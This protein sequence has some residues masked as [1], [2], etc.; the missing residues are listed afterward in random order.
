MEPFT[1]R[2]SEIVHAAIRIIAEK[3]IQELTT[4]NLAE[5]VGISEPALYRHFRNKTAILKGILDFFRERSVGIFERIILREPE[6][7]ARLA[8]VVRELCRHLADN[9]AF[10][11]VVFSEVIFRSESELA[12]GVEGL[13]SAARK[14]LS[15]IL[16]GGAE[17][18]EFRR[19]IPVEHMVLVVM[20]A[21]RLLATRWHLTGYGFD[22][23]AEGDAL[24]GSLVRLLGSPKGERT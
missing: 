19:D 22:L 13:M 18:G 12:P 14:N 20:G 4:K 2:Q 15:D 9:P 16:A 8:A 6:G 10:S 21:L 23:A 24:A 7:K 3:G 5:R 17:A 11:A 1:P